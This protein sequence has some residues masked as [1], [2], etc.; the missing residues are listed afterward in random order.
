MWIPRKQVF[1]G[2]CHDA[3]FFICSLA[4]VGCRVDPSCNDME[5]EVSDVSFIV[6]DVEFASRGNVWFGG[7]R[8]G[9]ENVMW[10]ILLDGG[11]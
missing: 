6:A 4:D 9:Q 11:I 8:L 5:S 10:D 7:C 2:Q 1:C 3:S